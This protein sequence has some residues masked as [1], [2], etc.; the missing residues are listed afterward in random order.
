MTATAAGTLPALNFVHI[1]KTAGTSLRALV[2]QHYPAAQVAASSMLR[3]HAER[4][5]RGPAPTALPADLSSVRLFAGHTNIA[6]ALPPEFRPFTVLRDPVSRLRSQFNHWQAW[7]PGDIETSPSSPEVKALKHR[8]KACTL[9]EFLSIDAPPVHRLFENGQCKTLV[10]NFPVAL[11]NRLKGDRLAAEAIGNLDTMLMVGLTERLDDS[12]RLLCFLLGWP[13]PARVERLNVRPRPRAADEAAL[14]PIVRAATELDQL[15]Y[16]HAVARFERDHESMLDAL[17]LP[18]GDADAVA[19]AIDA[20]SLVA[21]AE[22]PDPRPD[23]VD[24]RMD[25]GLRG[26]GWHE[27]EHTRAGHPYRWTGP[28]TRSTLDV[29]IRPARRYT[30][31]I[32][33]VSLLHRDV[34]KGARVLINGRDAASCKVEWRMPFLGHDP[35]MHA[36]H[37]EFDAAPVGDDG[38]CRLE[39]VVPR[40]HRHEDVE[41]GCGD[42]RD[43][44][45]AVTRV[46]IDPR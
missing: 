26:A 19:G 2:E 3:R 29:L 1:P 40:T 18:P 20:R 15:A 41:P 10:T 25:A 36:I 28:L 24:L 22:S 46:R 13:P 11:H 27:L 31:R 30:V 32:G 8:A 14:P 35:A 21:L 7:T 4:R 17:G 45:L 6:A 37:A 33:I 23:R 16:A 43:K 12:A 38:V 5:G 44:G 34:L 42:H 9:E 39:L